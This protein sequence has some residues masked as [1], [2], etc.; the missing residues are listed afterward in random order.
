MKVEMGK[1]YEFNSLDGTLYGQKFRRVL[2]VDVN[3]IFP[4]VIELEDGKLQTYTAKGT[5]YTLKK[6]ETDLVEIKGEQKKNDLQHQHLAERINFR[7][8]V[9]AENE[10]IDELERAAKPLFILFG[11]VALAIIY[12]RL[13]G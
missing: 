10:A 1:Q 7:A 5:S 6:S 8:V 3:G 9:A 4:V 11:L 12:G 13:Y 2:A